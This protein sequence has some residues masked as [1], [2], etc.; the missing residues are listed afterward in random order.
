MHALDH[1]ATAFIVSACPIR[2]KHGANCLRRVPM[3]VELRMCPLPP[4]HLQHH[5][6][7]PTA[8]A[9]QGGAVGPGPSS[10]AGEGG[11]ACAFWHPVR[12]WFVGNAA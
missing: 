10:G 2:T 11:C 9:N 5:V 7:A 6:D 4:S 1:D 3:A 12:Q 8:M